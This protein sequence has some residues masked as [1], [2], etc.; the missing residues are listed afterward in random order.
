MKVIAQLDNPHKLDVS[1][2]DQ[3]YFGASQDWFHRGNMVEGGCGPIMGMNISLY[4]G[5]LE[6]KD[7]ESDLRDAYDEIPPFELP[8]G[9]RIRKSKLKVPSTIGVFSL[10]RMDKFIKQYLG[11]KGLKVNSKS[12]V[13]TETKV[14]AGTCFGEL[15]L[16]IKDSLDQNH[17]LGLL[18][19]FRQSYI[20]V[21]NL[22]SKK[23]F[24][25]HWVMVTGLFQDVKG[26]YYLE[27]STWGKKG[28]INLTDLYHKKSLLD[29]LFQ[30]GMIKVK[31]K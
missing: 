13:Q 12:K 11:T 26:H 9:D 17:P 3:I 6:R 25:T 2:K 8:F 23:I 16:W 1:Y 28:L 21:D 19:T 24:R 7:L 5:L 27:C 10:K 15:L 4:L 30:S 22:R 20:Y 14:L 29:P 18:N 31:M